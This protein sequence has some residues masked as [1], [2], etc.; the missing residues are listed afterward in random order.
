MKGGHDTARP[1]G[2]EA[3]CVIL[4]GVIFQFEH[5]AS[6]EHRPLLSK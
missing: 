3:G 4:Q 1:V 6:Q 2:L 5:F